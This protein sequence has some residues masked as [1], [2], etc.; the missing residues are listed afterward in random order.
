LTTEPFIVAGPP[1]SGTSL[2]AG[3]LHRL[4]VSMGSEEDLFPANADNPTGYYEDI[5]FVFLN[6]AIL[7]EAGG[8]VW[9]PPT[10][11][12]IR[13]AA[14]D[15]S[16]IA[17]MKYFLK[18]R[19]REEPWGWKD[20]RNCLTIRS[21]LDHCSPRII[22]CNRDPVLIAESMVEF[23]GELSQDEAFNLATEYFERII[24]V[25]RTENLPYLIMHHELTL[26]EPRSAVSELLK[27]TGLDADHDIIQNAVEF[28]IPSCR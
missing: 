6:D 20:P 23:N 12:R 13:H 8:S 18:D 17:R 25:I 1:R 4:G 9:S 19:E 3:L 24:G 14:S 2:I 21:Y 28:V 7:S 10:Q 5:N 15:T 27:F 26:M 11:G 16:I 22:V